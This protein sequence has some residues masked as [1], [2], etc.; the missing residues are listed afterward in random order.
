MK[1]VRRP[2][3]AGVLTGCAAIWVVTLIWPTPA[4]ASSCDLVLHWDDATISDCIK[5]LKS[6]AF[7]LK[8]QV[9]TL[10]N[11]NR[12]LTGHI[13]L[14]ANEL[15]SRGFNSEATAMVSDDACAELKARAATKKRVAPRK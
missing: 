1:S 3:V 11:E 5:E 2:A 9:Q 10:A 6:D 13:C 8:L 14:L 12:I 15:K 4:N 7:I